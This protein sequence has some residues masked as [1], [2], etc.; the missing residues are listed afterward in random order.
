MNII[1][2]TLPVQQCCVGGPGS[3][4]V[5]NAAWT[6]GFSTAVQV[7]EKSWGVGVGQ[8]SCLNSLN[9]LSVLGRP[10]KAIGNLIIYHVH[11]SLLEY[12]H[13]IH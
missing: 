3:L 9:I 10:G 7:A 1:S 12:S 4:H 11:A 13:R 5:Y 2:T 6:M 8:R